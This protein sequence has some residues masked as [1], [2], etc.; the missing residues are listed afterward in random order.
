MP[1]TGSK[2]ALRLIASIR[3]Y[4]RGLKLTGNT[5]TD[6]ERQARTLTALYQWFTEK[7]KEPHRKT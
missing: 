5:I 2:T 1:G 6:P 3:A 4:Q 7:E